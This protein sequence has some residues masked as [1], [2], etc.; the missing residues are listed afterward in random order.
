MRNFLLGV[1]TAI[2][3]PIIAAAGLFLFLPKLEAWRDAYASIPSFVVSYPVVYAAREG[4]FEQA[5]ATLN[6]QADLAKVLGM[7][8]RM[9]RDLVNNTRFIMARARFRE[10]YAA[11]QPWLDRL[12]SI[13]QH[14]FLARLMAAEA[15]SYMEPAKAAKTMLPIRVNAPGFDRIYRPIME[16]SHDAGQRETVAAWCRHYAMGRSP[17]FGMFDFPSA[18][19]EGQNVGD[20][21]LELRDE[22][23]KLTLLPHE[24]FKL[25]ER[26]QYDFEFGVNPAQKFVRLHIPSLPGLKIISHGLA[27]DGPGGVRRFGSKDLDIVSRHGFFLDSKSTVVTSFQ[28]DIL[29]YATLGQVFPASAV[30]TF[31]LEFSRLPLSNHK[32]CL[33]SIIGG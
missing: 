26:R 22:A 17:A 1:M 4:D 15:K 3:L 19:Y 31:D 28:G 16:A 7:N 6:R 5:A 33:N 12:A 30:I 23:G 29:T 27:F 2:I 24:G 10:H 13:A 9:R 32:T 8:S 11:M 14:N 18:T 20:F 21:F 25:N